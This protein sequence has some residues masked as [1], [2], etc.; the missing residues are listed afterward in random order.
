MFQ[1]WEDR[2]FDTFAQSLADN[3]S[4]TTVP[5]GQQV[6]GKQQVLDWYKSWADAFSDATAGGKVTVA[7]DDGVTMEGVFQG[8]NDGM[9]A[10]LFQPTN[11]RVSLPWIN[12]L[13]F[14]GGKVSE[15]AAY[16]DSLALMVQ[17]GHVQPPQP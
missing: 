6:S 1:A 7:G 14:S 11:Q 5:G 16:F 12:V 8:N 10:G 13:H 4:I 2:D 9:F 17:L 3:V 15:V